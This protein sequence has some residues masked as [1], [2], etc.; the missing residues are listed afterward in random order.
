MG[1]REPWSR[2]GALGSKVKK[3]GING[4][5][6][7]LNFLF[8]SGVDWEDFDRNMKM[9]R[10]VSSPRVRSPGGQGLIPRTGWEGQI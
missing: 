1:V 3:S 10:E 2:L 6:L 9:A 4:K 7:G 5:S 8:K